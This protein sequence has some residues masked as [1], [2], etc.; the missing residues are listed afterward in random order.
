MTDTKEKA[1]AAI[2]E[3]M[4]GVRQE[5]ERLKGNLDHAAFTGNS[6]IHV[7]AGGWGVW[8]ATTCCIVMLAVGLFAGVFFISQNAEQN[9]EISDLKDYIQVIYQHAPHLK[10]DED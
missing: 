1:S 6:T 5:L 4:E 3:E 2:H 9:R 10:P 7:N 8:A